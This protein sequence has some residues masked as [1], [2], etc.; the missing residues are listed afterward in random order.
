MLFSPKE[1]QDIVA[2]IAA[3]ERRTTGEIRMFIESICER[4]H[5][6]ERAVEV[7]QLH[8]MYHTQ[9]RNAVLLYLAY[10]SRQF[11]IWGDSG[12]HEIVGHNFWEAE[13]KLLRTYLQRDEA[14]AGICAVIAQIGEQLRLHFPASPDDDNPNELPDEIIYG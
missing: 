10:D 2:A 4:D 12:I 6:V 3:A 7:F 1:E 5:P 11:A 9:M 8:G 13:K 14:A